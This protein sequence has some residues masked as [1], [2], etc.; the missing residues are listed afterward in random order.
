M[1]ELW[2]RP[3]GPVLS[4]LNW[5]M[6]HGE[7]VTIEGLLAQVRPKLAVEI[8]TAQGGTLD[9]IAHYSEEVHTFDL[10]HQVDHADFP[11]VTFH[12]G[13]NHVL[14]PEVL[15]GFEREGRN[16]DFAI[17]DG[18]HTA[19]GVRK[20]VG[21]LLGSGA[22][23]NTFI[24]L[25]DTMNEE[26]LEGLN[27]IDYNAYPN[28]VFFDLAFTQSFQGKLP[29]LQEAWCGLGLIVVDTDGVTGI[30]PRHRVR[31]RGPLARARHSTWLGLAPVRALK[32]RIHHRGG[33]IA[34]RLRAART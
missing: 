34:R 22:V 27:S 19:P 20:D 23:R 10:T 28:I 30:T 33:H 15:M 26:V 5:Q 1:S 16:V 32:R 6:S 12:Q 14:L 2:S 29:L 21:Q 4:R 25:H 17:V 24:L 8:G 11:N 31:D 9:R 3:G 7:R 13:D 18:D